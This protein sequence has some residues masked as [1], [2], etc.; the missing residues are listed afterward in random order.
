MNIGRDRGEEMQNGPGAG[1][2]RGL[3]GVL[4]LLINIYEIVDT[5]F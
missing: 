4:H 2:G 1:R 3:E 5:F